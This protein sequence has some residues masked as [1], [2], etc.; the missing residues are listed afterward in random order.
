MSCRI[1]SYSL[2]TVAVR[3]GAYAAK[4]D[5]DYPGDGCNGLSW[6]PATAYTFLNRVTNYQKDNK[7]I[8]YNEVRRRFPVSF[9]QPR[10]TTSTKTH[11]PTHPHPNT[12]T[13]M[14]P[15]PPQPTQSTQTHLDPDP[16]TPPM[17][18]DSTHSEQAESRSGVGVRLVFV[19]VATDVVSWC[20]CVCM[21]A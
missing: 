16:S 8:F 5:E 14:H 12:Q 19:V 17:S 7:R 4:H 15:R 21:C 10:L 13:R 6:S 3:R 9:S 2:L 20:V 18:P 11:P 1:Y